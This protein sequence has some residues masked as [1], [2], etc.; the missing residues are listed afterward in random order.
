MTMSRT[1]SHLSSAFQSGGFQSG[2]FQSGFSQSSLT[3]TPSLNVSPMSVAPM[4]VSSLPTLPPFDN[5]G[6]DPAHAQSNHLQGAITLVEGFLRLPTNGRAFATYL[7]GLTIVFAGGFMHVWLAAQI[8]QAEV[9]LA[10]LQEDRL[11]LE[12]QNGDLI[13]KIAEKSSLPHLY[14]RVIELGFVPV[15]NRHYIIDDNQPV[16]ATAGAAPAAEIAA[17]QIATEATAQVTVAAL[18]T[19]TSPATSNLGGQVARWESFWRSL[20]PTR[21]AAAPAQSAATTQPAVPMSTNSNPNFWAAWWEQASE[22]GSKF[23]E[24]FG[25]Q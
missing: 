11:A 15:E 16:L 6:L 14:K 23:L 10:R 12:Q 21:P 3:S 25:G 19:A 13:F 2:N 24:Q 1:S 9:T 8:M 4:S 5:A 18:P 7:L 20:W 17:A 22:Q